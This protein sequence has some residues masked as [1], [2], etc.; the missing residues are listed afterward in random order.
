MCLLFM[1]TFP[2]TLLPT[3]KFRFYFAVHRAV[4]HTPEMF[5]IYILASW[6]G[7]AGVM[8]NMAADLFLH[9]QL[10]KLK[11]ETS[12][13][14]FRPMSFPL[15]MGRFSWRRIFFIKEFVPP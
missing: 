7:L 13:L 5:S 3:V 11:P 12:R 6:S 14:T 15:P 9:F 1:M 8:R 10:L 4:K 2:S